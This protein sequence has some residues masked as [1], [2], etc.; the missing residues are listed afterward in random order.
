MKHFILIIIIAF[1]LPALA[2]T[3]Y[4]TSGAVLQNCRVLEIGEDQVKVRL[5]DKETIYPRQEISRI[6]M[7][8]GSAVPLNLRVETRKPHLFLLPVAA[9]GIVLAIDS[10]NSANDI[11]KQIDWWTYWNEH[12]LA[13]YQQD[14]IR[15]ENARSRK[16]VLAWFS[17]GASAV[18]TYFAFKNITIITAPNQVQLTYRF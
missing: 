13:D 3:L 10:F 17:L 1:C 7:E 5:G 2:D 8:D 15:M 16:Q 6:V 12:T 9:A 4:F 14:I 11:S 18:I